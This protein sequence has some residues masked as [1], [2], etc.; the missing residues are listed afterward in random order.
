MGHWVV[1]QGPKNGR[2]SAMVLL[3]SLKLRKKALNQKLKFFSK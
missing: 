3:E 2:I 1:N